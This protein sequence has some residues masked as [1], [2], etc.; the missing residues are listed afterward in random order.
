MKKK[1]F[2]LAA[3]LIL[4]AFVFA[5][6]SNINQAINDNISEIYHGVYEG[7]SDKASVKVITGERE[8]DFAMDGKSGRKVVFCVITLSPETGFSLPEGDSKYG[9]SFS[10]GGKPYEGEF[11]SDNVGGKP[12]AE[13]QTN[14]GNVPEFKI[15][16]RAGD[17]ETEITVTSK[18]GADIITYTQALD[19]AKQEF[20]NELEALYEN[21]NLGCEIFIRYINSAG[22]SESDYL[23][24]VAFLQ[25]DK[26]FFAVLVDPVSSAILAK[27]S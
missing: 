14:L 5:A 8:K 11:T 23:W 10:F 21:G 26:T 15:T 2:L 16:V 9:Y 20:K 27:R 4:A 19:L 12:T 24:Y 7:S 13:I 22:S 6:C 3:M 1:V 17:T 25:P 18:M